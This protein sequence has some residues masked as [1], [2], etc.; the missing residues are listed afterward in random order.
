M[1]DMTSIRGAADNLGVTEE[2]IVTLIDQIADDPELW[3]SEN[4][5][6]TEAGMEILREQ[7]STSEPIGE[8]LL[9][10]V[11]RTAHIAAIAKAVA[12]EARK[13]RDVAVRAAVAYGHK[14]TEVAE[15]AGFR[16]ERLYQIL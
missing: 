10:E 12:D 13:A 5:Q 15:R 2:T 4:Q 14:R 7:L 3:D 9:A 6:I 11:E 8:D 16:R 1:N